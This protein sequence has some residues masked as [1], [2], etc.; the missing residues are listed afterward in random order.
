MNSGLRSVCAGWVRTGLGRGCERGWGEAARSVGAAAWAACRRMS[1]LRYLPTYV[2]L[3]ASA[4]R[5]VGEAGL[6]VAAGRCARVKMDFSHAR[7]A[8]TN[9]WCMVAAFMQLQQHGCGNH[10]V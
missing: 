9:A 8:S 1:D 3:V 7:T 10:A 5:A 6:R 2:A 4:S